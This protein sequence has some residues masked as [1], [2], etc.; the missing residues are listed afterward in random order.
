[1]KKVPSIAVDGVVFDKNSVLLIERL[2]EPYKGHS[3]LPGG[4][5]DF[6]E[7][8]EET[9][10]RE[11]FEET[12]LKTR[13][14]QFVGLYDDPKRDPRGHVITAVYILEKTG[15]SIRNSNETTNVRFWALNKLP[16]DMAYD[17]RQIIK[18]ALKLY[19]KKR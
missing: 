8:L 13:V 19:K 9:V 11:V 1:M 5:V 6:G 17:C 12:G 14:V 2:Q 15:G 4:F 7:R 16:K 3:V 18:D 10:V